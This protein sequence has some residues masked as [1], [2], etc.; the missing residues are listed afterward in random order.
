[1][2]GT[3]GRVAIA[4][5][6]LL[7]TA[8]TNSV[9]PFAPEGARYNGGS[10]G[11]GGRDEESADTTVA[12]GASTDQTEAICYDDNGGSMGSGGLVIVPCPAP[13]K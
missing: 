9:Q 5:G 13:A 10:M 3:Y 7:L 12:A 6:A 2:T 8:C 4:M 1:M 11:S